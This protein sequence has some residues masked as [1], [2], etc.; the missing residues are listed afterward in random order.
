MLNLKNEY[1]DIKNITHR[2]Q[3]TVLNIEDADAKEQIL[4]DLLF[5]LTAKHKRRTN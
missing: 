4:L 5:A 2:V 1:T 3:H